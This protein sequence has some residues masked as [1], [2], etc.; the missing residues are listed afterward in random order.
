MRKYAYRALE[1]ARRLD[2]RVRRATRGAGRFIR[3]SINRERL[4]RWGFYLGL[5]ALM[6]LLGLGS[7]GYRRRFERA[8]AVETPAPQA[9]MAVVTP[10]PEETPE[11]R[12][13]VWPVAGEVIRAFSGDTLAWSG[14]LG[15]WQTHPAVDIAASP[16]EAVCACADGVVADLWEDALW[17][18]VIAIDHGDGLESIYANLN[19]LALVRVGDRVAAGQ[20]ISS[21]GR[22][23]A[24]ESDLPWH[25]HFA[26][27][28]DGERVDFEK[29]MRKNGA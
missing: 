8:Q 7:Q 12:R 27:E 17:G 25:L 22:S 13:F 18:N 6:V 21:A 16:G 2:A 23:A 10:T 5:A 11:P 1:A 28:R 4:G 26:L 9:A 19:T 15:Q 3:Q 24:C 29:F 20:V 14:A